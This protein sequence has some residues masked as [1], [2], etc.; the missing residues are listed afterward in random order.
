LDLRTRRLFKKNLLYAAFI[1]ISLISSV[2]IPPSGGMAMISAYAALDNDDVN[3][4]KMQFFTS[5]DKDHDKVDDKVNSEN[6]PFDILVIPHGRFSSDRIQKI[7]SELP[8][9]TITKFSSFDWIGISNVPKDKVHSISKRSEIQF[10]S[11]LGKTGSYDVMVGLDVASGAVKSKASTVYT[12]NTATDYGITGAGVNI[13]VI[14]TGVDDEIHESLKGKFV[15]GYNAITDTVENPIDDNGHGTHVAG[16]ALGS[17]GLSGTYMGVAPGAGLVDVKVLDATGSGTWMDVLKGIDFCITNKNTYNIKIISLSLAAQAFTDGADAPSAAV[18]QAVDAGVVA[19]VCAGNFGSMGYNTIAIPGASSKAITVGALDDL[20]SI[21][22][23]DDVIASYSSRGPRTNNGDLDP[24]DELKPELT[25]P[26]TDII[27]AQYKTVNGYVSLSGC[28]MAT[29]IVAGIVALTLQDQPWLTPPQIKQWLVSNAEDKGLVYSSTLDPRYDFDYGYGEVQFVKNPE[30]VLSYPLTQAT[31]TKSSTGFSTYSGRQAHVEYVSPSSTLAGKQIDSIT[32]QLRKQ[33]SPTGAATIG[34]FAPDLTM[35][36]QFGALLDTTKVATTYTNYTFTLQ[37]NEL[38]TVVAGDRIGIKYSGGSSANSIAVMTDKT[39]AFDGGGSFRQAYSTSWQSSTSEDLYMV[40]KQSHRD[41][42]V[43]TTPL[44]VT[45]TPSDGGY[46]SAQTVTLTA[47]KQATTI[48]YTLDGRIPTTSSSKYAQPITISSSTTLKFFG[49]TTGG[50]TSPVTTKLYT[51]DSVPPVVKASPVG[52]LYGSAQLVTLSSNKPFTTIYYT[53]DGTDPTPTSAAYGSP[54]SITNTTVLKF[55]GRDSIGNNG[56]ISAETYTID[57]IPPTV[58]AMPNGG[59]Y[60]DSLSVAIIASEP[61]TIYYTL[62]GSEPTPSSQVYISPIAISTNSTLEFIAVDTAGN[63]SPIFSENYVIDTTAPVI[64]ASPSGGLYNSEQLVTLTSNKPSTTIY[65]TIDGSLPSAE[66]D[67]AYT[68][69]ILISA[70]TTLKFYGEDGL[71]NV[72]SIATQTYTIDSVPPLITASPAGGV[73]NQT[74]SVTLTS[75]ELSTTIYYTTDGSIP[76]TES[77]VYNSSIV[78]SADTTLNFFGKD[79]A[80][81]AGSITTEEYVIDTEPPVS[82]ITSVTD[83]DGRTLQYGESTNST[84]IAFEFNANDNIRVDT[85]E[86]KID[87]GKYQPCLGEE[88]TVSDLTDGSHTFYVRATDTAGNV[89]SNPATFTFI[90]DLA[91]PTVIAPSDVVQEA[92][93]PLTFL[94]LGNATALDTIDGQIATITNDAPIAG[95]PVGNTN[96]TWSAM[97]SAG[98]IGMAIQQVTITD[99]TPPA[100]TIPLDITVEASGALTAITLG[101]ATAIDLV[102]GVVAVTSDTPAESKFPVGTTIVTYTATDSHSNTVH[103]N[104][105]VIVQDTAAPVTTASPAAGTYTS[106]QNITLTSTLSPRTTTIYYTTDGSTPTLSSPSGPTPLSGI[107]ISKT[108]DLMFFAVDS[109]G[110]TESV[111]TAHYIINPDTAPLASSDSFT[112]VQDRPKELMLNAT[113]ADGDGLTYIIVSGPSNGTIS[114]GSNASRTYTPTTGYTGTDSFTFKVNDGLSDSNIA[115][116]NINVIANNTTTFPIIQM[117]DT[118]TTYGLSTHSGRQSHVEVVT[119]SSALVGKPIDQITLRLRAA[120]SPIGIAQIGVFDSSVGLNKLFGT[121]DATTL[122]KTYRDYTFSLSGGDLYTLQSGDRIGI[123]FTGGD[124]SNSVAIMTDQDP[125]G[126][127]DGT[128]TYHT[129][130]TT[131]WHTFTTKDLY[132]ILE[133][134]HA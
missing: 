64:A 86:C 126:P 125:A 131:S 2:A 107:I 22:R 133:Q 71:G 32:L 81:N 103:A 11:M 75:D 10:I 26:G 115:T 94:A 44:V 114:G 82:A 124:A 53:T 123:K 72:G 4:E 100:L 47:N 19:T 21:D 120:G 79:A 102:D 67:L 90:V 62:D 98:N 112:A 80:E 128:N 28:S 87:L 88:T 106:A 84:S 63:I 27:S 16:I 116:V 29:P 97:D 61:A 108:G 95:F 73:Y 30:S 57:T 83:G 50:V 6:G 56:T 37:N 34:I 33:G 12:P 134:T 78:I 74:K 25:A 101:N 109:S 110:N 59:T 31:D 54:I 65:Y 35:K 129:Y 20:N 55:F 3:D 92:T 127:F 41:S 91:Q 24:L 46:S 48:Y 9:S 66:P 69:P 89:E 18:N 111:K 76:T 5:N 49:K 85:I 99:T 58:T 36:K 68:V 7:A 23:S 70:D 104:Q 40:L 132:M 119:P 96:V 45:A 130:Y 15:A 105:T 60:G 42:T 113:D 51:I 121:I 1:S 14:D 17:G 8:G 38:Y 118:T 39:G 93:G 43:D 13:C 122:T 117:S 77:T 52:G